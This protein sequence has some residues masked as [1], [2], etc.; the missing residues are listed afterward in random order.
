MDSELAING[1]EPRDNQG[2]SQPGARGETGL[3]QRSIR[4]LKGLHNREV[5][6][7]EDGISHFRLKYA[8]D[9]ITATI[10]KLEYAHNILDNFSR[11]STRFLNLEGALERL[12]DLEHT[13]WVGIGEDLDN[14]LERLT[15]DS[16]SYEEQYLATIS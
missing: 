2:L 6:R 16:I 10:A 13:T 5:N 14:V 4:N 1:N 12:R 8:E 3:L 15:Q 11:C 7:C 9:Y